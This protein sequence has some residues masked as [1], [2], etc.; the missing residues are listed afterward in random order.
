MTK[1]RELIHMRK[2]SLCQLSSNLSHYV[3][4]NALGWFY[5]AFNPLMC[6]SLWPECARVVLFSSHLFYSLPL[7]MGMISAFHLTQFLTPG[8]ADIWGW[9]MLCCGLSCTFWD[10]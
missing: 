5:C 10:M 8:T 4:E 1:D 2:G 9:V 3:D 7:F 6:N